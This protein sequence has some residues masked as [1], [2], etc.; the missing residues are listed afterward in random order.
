MAGKTTN[1]AG[2][3]LYAVVLD[4]ED[5]LYGQIGLDSA[6]V[7]TVAKGRIAAVVSDVP[8]GRIR[9]ER[10][11]LAC[12][13]EVMRRLLNETTPLPMSFGIIA[14]D[15]RA[16]NRILSQNQKG[17]L[18]QLLRLEGKVEMGLHVLWDVPN[19]FEFFV[20]T[21][22]ELRSAR[23]LFLGSHREPTQEEK[24]E[25][26]R[27]FERILQEDRESY[28]ESV[29]EALTPFC[30][31]IR[32]NSPRNEREVLSL[33][34]LVRKEDQASFENGVFEAASLF[35]HNFTFDYNGPW[36]PHNFVEMKIR[37]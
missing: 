12:H 3:Y 2:Y 13:Q 17:F 24:I 14:R 4:A 8:A 21:H 25:V 7:Y 35:D 1:G 18:D 11:H 9:P 23:D 27:M 5:R 33:A 32:S 28:T 20:L 15:R 19:I 22:P 30:V 29:R 37:I 34:C 31:E 26:G 10:R 6:L 36:A 16:L